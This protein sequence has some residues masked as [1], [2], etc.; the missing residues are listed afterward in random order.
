MQVLF[1]DTPE[2]TQRGTKLRSRSFT[3]VAMDFTSAITFIIPR[4][5]VATMADHGMGW[6]TGPVA[7]PFVG[8]QPHAAS[9]TVVGDEGTASPRVCVVAHPKAGL[10][11]IPRDDADDGGPIVGIDPMLLPLV[12]TPRG[13]IR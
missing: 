11:R 3:G 12:G 6:M 13:R 5:L 1:V 9:R 10:A 8:V 2:G 7:L 4:P